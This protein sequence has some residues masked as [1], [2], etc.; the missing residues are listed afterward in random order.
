MIYFELKPTPQLSKYVDKFWYCHSANFANTTL[1]IPILYHEL[2]FNFSDYYCLSRHGEHYNILE[3]PISWISGI[4]TRPILSTCGGK[5]EMMGVLFKPNGLKAFTKYSS[6]EFE[7]S[8]IDS[9]LVFDE[10]FHVL[11]EQIQNTNLAMAK[12]SLIE[13]YLIHN[14]NSDNYPAYLKTSLELFELPNKR[15]I[16]IKET[17]K[18]I[19]ITNKSLIKS[20]QKHIGVTPSKY[21]QLR[22]INNAVSLLSKDPQ[23]SFTKLAYG[24]NFYD[25]AHFIHLFKSTTSLTPSQ[26]SDCVLKNLV[27]KSSPNFIPIAG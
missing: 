25:Q 21:L 22:A 6:S 24:L 9:S 17:C 13:N 1:T 14:L 19:S 8:F 18:E 7:N 11:I 26:Y 10:S 2:V 12:L 20:F 15:K 3:N 5:H 23:Q 27:D 16:S 4:Q